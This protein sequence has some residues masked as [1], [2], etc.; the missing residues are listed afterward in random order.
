MTTVQLSTSF[1]RPVVGKDVLVGVEVTKL[2][3]TL[4][5]AEIDM[6]VDSATV[7]RASAVYAIIG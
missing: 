1:Q 2:G 4:A 6:T 5:F 7:A 3:R